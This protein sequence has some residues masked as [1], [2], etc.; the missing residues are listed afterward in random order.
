MGGA[1]CDLDLG[2]LGEDKCQ[3]TP[4]FLGGTWMDGVQPEMGAWT[5]L[6][7]GIRCCQG[8]RWEHGGP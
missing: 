3:R 8:F 2:V 1:R 4:G 5:G 7:W 6:G